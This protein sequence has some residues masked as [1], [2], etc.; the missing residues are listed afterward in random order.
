MLSVRR[1][2]TAVLPPVEPVRRAGPGDLRSAVAGPGTAD[3]PSAP[4]QHAGGRRGGPAGSPGTRQ[5]R[6]GRALRSLL[7]SDARLRGGAATR[8]A[9]GTAPVRE[10]RRRALD[11]AG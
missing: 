5:G 3:R 10:R 4:A 9:P 1:G 7:R 11:V 2:G 6:A 8:R